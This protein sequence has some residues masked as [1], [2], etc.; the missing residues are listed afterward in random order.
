M[1]GRLRRFKRNIAFYAVLLAV[2]GFFGFFV[3]NLHGLF[4]HWQDGRQAWENSEIVQEI[5][6]PQLEAIVE[7]AVEPAVETETDPP[8]PDAEQ[9]PMLDAARQLT[10]NDDI[11]AFISIPG[12][13]I[14]NIVVQA[15]DNEYYLSRDAF[16]NDNVNGALFMDFR[17][18]RDFADKSTVIYGHNMRNGS[19]FH[20]L[21][22][23][24]NRDFFEAHPHILIIT[25][26]NI[27]IYEIFAAFSTNIDF[28]YIQVHFE[29]P[30]EFADLIN[31]IIARSN[32]NTD[33]S[34]TEADQILILS[35]C[36]NIREDTRFVIAG[37]LQNR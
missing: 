5:F 14:G 1:A 34:P 3:F 23:F 16:G 32:H 20:N 13:N 12:T 26:Y 8:P 28:Y 19:M 6:A 36:T 10:G 29:S 35:T 27:L 31:E 25:D 22:H 11:V 33:I 15:A 17:N 18:S 2:V 7:A 30:A 9:T 21:R 37:R 24:M 4:V